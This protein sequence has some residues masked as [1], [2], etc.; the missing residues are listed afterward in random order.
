MVSMMSAWESTVTLMYGN[1]S[2]SFSIIFPWQPSLKAR[3]S[4]C[5][6]VS[7]PASTPLIRFASSI[8]SRRPLTKVQ[9]VICSGLILMTDVVGVSHQEVLATA[10]ARTS[11]SSLITPI[12]WRELH[13]LTSLSWMDTIGLTSATL[14]QSSQLPTTATAAVT[15]LLSWK[16][17]ST[18]NSI[19]K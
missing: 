2:Q 17:T 1:S 15:R 9:S 18:W 4:A 13:V 3:S 10:S 12:T 14:L 11:Q 16:S 5:T 7:P 6:V 19:C 8:A